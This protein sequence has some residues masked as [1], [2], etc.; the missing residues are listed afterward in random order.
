MNISLP[1]LAE[2]TSK[3][4]KIKRTRKCNKTREIDFQLNYTL[5]ASTPEIRITSK[6]PETSES[7]LFQI[8]SKIPADIRTLIGKE[9]CT[10][11]TS[12]SFDDSLYF[13]ELKTVTTGRILL[14]SFVVDSTQSFLRDYGIIS[15]EVVF[16]SDYQEK[17][18]GRGKN[19]WL[20]PLGGLFFSFNCTCREA[21]NLPFIQYLVCLAVIKAITSEASSVLL[22]YGI[23]S[24]FIENLKIKWPNDIYYKN[25]KI[26]GILCHSSYANGMYHVTNGIGLNLDNV[27]P[28][29]CINS[30]LFS[31]IEEFKCEEKN[32]KPANFLNFEKVGK[33]KLLAKI[34]EC[35]EEYYQIFDS[36]GFKALEV[37]EIFTV[38]LH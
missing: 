31:V 23:A 32:R 26:G 2:S 38:L 33:E 17:G 13:N 9:T 12:A 22:R 5:M 19:S 18:C 35:F 30:L 16:V 20:S 37:Q 4:L 27:A 25:T 1:T 28:T 11:F 7:I 6:S 3:V 10:S 8:R 21:K 15:P 29:A 36:K 14:T 34:L 24:E